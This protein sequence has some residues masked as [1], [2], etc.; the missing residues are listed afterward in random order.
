MGALL[1]FF[2]GSAFRAIWGEISHWLSSAQEHK[3]ELARLE[4]QS[5]LDAQKHA[6]DME[7]IKLQADLSAKA[8]TVQS[9][10]DV[11]KTEADAFLE[12][13]KDYSAPSGIKF[14]DGW[15]KS[16]R[17]AFAS[18]SLFL[19]VMQLYNQQWIMSGF[20]LDLFGS[21]VGYVFA[22]RSL[23]HRGK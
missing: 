1:S 12:A 23:A 8:I 14:I 19:W 16:I 18:V 22:D 21:I 6:Q 17:P 20:D 7:S 9:D 2:G 3:Q 4:A 5:K 13:I 15:V 11:K 10:A